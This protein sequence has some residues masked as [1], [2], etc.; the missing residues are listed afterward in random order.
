MENNRTIGQNFLEK[1]LDRIGGFSS[2]HE[3]ILYY[4]DERGEKIRPDDLAERTGV[5]SRTINKM[6]SPSESE[7]RF[8][9]KILI[10]IAV[11]LHMIAVHS[12]YLIHLNGHTLRKANREEKFY[13]Y[14]LTECSQY[15]VAEVNQFLI[16]HDLSPLTNMESTNE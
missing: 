12:Y 3:L 8:D 15:T 14:I 4:M 1:D 10:A 2:F 13:I 6:R 5:S 9:L 7:H 16:D 11:G